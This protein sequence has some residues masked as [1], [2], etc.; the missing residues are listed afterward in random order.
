MIG[1]ASTPNRRPGVLHRSGVIVADKCIVPTLVTK[2]T[3]AVGGLLEDVTTY[4]LSVAPGNSFGSAG[5][6]NVLSQATGAAAPHTHCITLTVPKVIGAGYYDV[7]LS[8]D[9]APKWVGRITELQRATGGFQIQAYGVVTPGGGNAAGTVLIGVVGIGLQTSAAPFINNNAYIV[10][11][12]PNVIDGSDKNC[13]DVF[14]SYTSLDFRSLPGLV[15]IPFAFNSV[16]G[17]YYQGGPL[18][19]NIMAGSVGQ[20]MLQW[21]SV[22]VKSI[23]PG[24]VGSIVILVDSISGNGA[25][26]SIMSEAV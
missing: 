17:L 12:I 22:P 4:Y 13:V 15:I 21:C 16:D 23:I 25:S 8:V 3:A 9:V 2:S 5:V 6:A 7:F 24:V 26:V 19:I 10:P 11:S 18:R 14:V 1:L 20:T